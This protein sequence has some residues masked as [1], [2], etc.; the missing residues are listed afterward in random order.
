MFDARLSYPIY[1]G[2]DGDR[3]SVHLG[4]HVKLPFP[5]S[6]AMSLGL[7]KGDTFNIDEWRPDAVLWNLEEE[8][9]HVKFPPFRSTD[10]SG[11]RSVAEHLLTH[12]WHVH[13]LCECQ[14]NWETVSFDDDENYAVVET[15]GRLFYSDES[16]LWCLS[17]GN[18]PYIIRRNIGDP[19]PPRRGQLTDA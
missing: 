1:T 16:E 8:R 13:F 7:A 2:G 9:F 12:G 15:R 11:G 6:T 3:F 4:R 17:I 19:V 18:D 14:D 5:P 10:S